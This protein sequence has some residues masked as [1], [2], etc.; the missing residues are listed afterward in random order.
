MLLSFA[1]F[2]REVTG[3]RKGRTGVEVAVGQDRGAGSRPAWSAGTCPSP[4]STWQVLGMVG[5]MSEFLCWPEYDH[6]SRR[7]GCLLPGLRV[8]AQ[9]LALLAHG[10]GAEIN[11]P[12]RLTGGETIGDKL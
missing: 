4:R 9:A 2:E 7:D 8:A 11:D 5:V 1:Q 12:H 10:E 3:E 6:T